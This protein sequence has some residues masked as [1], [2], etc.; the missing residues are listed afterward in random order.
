M[1]FAEI[2]KTV[3][4]HADVRVQQ[5][6]HC[7]VGAQLARN[8]RRGEQPREY[9]RLTIATTNIQPGH[10]LNES[11]MPYVGVIVWIPKAE[12]DRLATQ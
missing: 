1:T 11:E 7:I 3:I 9:T 12:Y 10:L 4:D 2:L 6:S 5:I 8:K